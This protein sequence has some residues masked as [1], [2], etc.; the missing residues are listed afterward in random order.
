M[1]VVLR[2]MGCGDLDPGQLLAGGA[3]LM[4]VAH[5]AHAVNVVGGGVVGGLEILFGA[6]GTRRHGASARLA[7]ERDQRNRATPGGNGFGGV[8]EMDQ[9]GASS[10]IGGVE[11][12]HLEAYV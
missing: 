2:V 9:I 5:G 6:G 8:A 1:L 10:G 12:A 3:E 7:G 4:H 11:M